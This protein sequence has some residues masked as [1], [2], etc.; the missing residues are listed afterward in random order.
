[1]FGDLVVTRSFNTGLRR[2]TW[3]PLGHLTLK[4]KGRLG[5]HQVSKRKKEKSN[6]NQ[7]IRC[8]LVWNDLVAT[9]SPSKKI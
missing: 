1:M 9:K 3:W 5:G 4:C 2:M 8:I 6:G 7:V